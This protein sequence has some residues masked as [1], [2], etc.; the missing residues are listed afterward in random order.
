MA[1]KYLDKKVKVFPFTSCSLGWSTKK[2]TNICIIQLCANLVKWVLANAAGFLFHEMK[3]K[4]GQKVVVL[5]DN[6]G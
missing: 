4:G 5:A 2:T 6:R 1:L 3:G